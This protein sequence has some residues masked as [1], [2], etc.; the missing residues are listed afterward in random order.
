MEARVVI[1]EKSDEING[2]FFVVAAWFY[3]KVF[4][5]GEFFY[6]LFF[7]SLRGL[8]FF[9]RQFERLERFVTY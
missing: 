1:E 5:I 2:Y 4:W 8:P 6:S 9:A 7:A 3:G